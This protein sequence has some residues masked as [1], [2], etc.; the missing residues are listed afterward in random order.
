MH[1]RRSRLETFLMRQLSAGGPVFIERRGVVRLPHFLPLL[2]VM[3]LCLSA[4]RPAA[5]GEGNGDPEADAGRDAAAE[6]FNDLEEVFLSAEG[7]RIV[8]DITSEGAFEA[9]LAGELHLA[10]GNHLRLEAEGHFGGE[11]MDLAMAS[12]GSILRLLVNGE[13]HDFKSPVALNEA[14]VLGLTRMGLLHNL[15]LLTTARPPDHGDGGVRDWVQA[16]DL[17]PIAGDPETGVVFGMVVD[18]EPAGRAELY[19]GP[20]GLPSERLQVVEFPEGQMRV[21]ESYELVEL[22]ARFLEWNFELE[23]PGQGN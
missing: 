17:E 12:N 22:D 11:P 20:L 19:L 21:V 8:F 15:A 10:P 23:E 9:R 4:C 18:G 2:V 13:V 5:T 16:E 7:A 14:V 3:S 1:V 6:T